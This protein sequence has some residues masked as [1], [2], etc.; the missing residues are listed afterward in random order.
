MNNNLVNGFS[1]MAKPT[2]SRCNL[3]CSYCY[4]LEK[5]KLYPG[6]TAFNMDQETLETF[7]RKYIHEHPGR[8]VHFVWQGGEPTLA[9]IEFYRKALDLQRKYGSGKIVSN[10]FQTNGILLNDNWCSFFRDNNFLI[11]ISIDG[12]QD[13]HDR[14][15]L[16]KGGQGSFQK[17]M[18]AIELLKKHRVEFNTLTVVNNITVGKPLEIYRFLKSIGSHYMQFIPLVERQRVNCKTDELSLISP[19]YEGKWILSPWSVPS[20]A[21][22]KFLSAIFD[23]WVK[24]DVGRYFIPTFDS[25]LANEAGIPA[26]LCVFNQRCGN[27][28]AIEHNGD[29]F[30]CD[31]FVYPQ[32]K[33][34]NIRASTFKKMLLSQQNEKFG[35]EKFDN[36]PS[37]CTK[38]DVYVYCRGECPKH[39][40]NRTTS[41]ETGLNYL[42]EGYKLFFRH[43]KPAMKFMVNELQHRRSPANIMYTNF[44]VNKT[45]Y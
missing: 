34:G 15:R 22:G 28:L 26:G 8:E 35:N 5:E 21:F 37:C 43:I 6:K 7:T 4:Y 9:G 39:R 24:S 36:L 45:R 11:G 29:V 42:C 16:T 41:G 19:D 44:P 17:V 38:C 20:L 25:C 13:L 3:D 33:L 1:S 40:F 30:S 2:G 12:P 23:E 14:Y 18:K 31:H 27:A 10:S 32:Y